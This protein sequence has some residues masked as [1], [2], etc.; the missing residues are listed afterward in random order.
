MAQDAVKVQRCLPVPVDLEANQCSNLYVIAA[1][2][3]HAG[4]Y[5]PGPAPDLERAYE[6]CHF[7]ASRAISGDEIEQ[8]SENPVI[9]WAVFP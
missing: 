1:C 7:I 5:S 8:W 2:T 3:V 4:G 9:H 6:N